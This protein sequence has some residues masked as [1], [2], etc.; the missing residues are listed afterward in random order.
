MDKNNE[1]EEIS[2]R[3]ILTKDNDKPLYDYFLQ[4][5]QNLGIKNNTE[6][7][8]ICIKKAYEYWFKDK[9]QII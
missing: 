3:L 8:R 9:T 2:I 6:V 7:A 4:I 1:I 5:K